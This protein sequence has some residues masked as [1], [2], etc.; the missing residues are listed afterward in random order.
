MKIFRGKVEMLKRP[1]LRELP[2]GVR[3]KNIIVTCNYP[4]RKLGLTKAKKIWFFV[5][6]SDNT[7]AECFI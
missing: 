2:L 5:W 3:Q 7:F 6:K 1:D 4:A